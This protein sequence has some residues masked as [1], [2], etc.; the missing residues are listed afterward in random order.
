MK[1]LRLSLTR[2]AVLGG[3][4]TGLLAVTAMFPSGARAMTPGTPGGARAMKAGPHPGSGMNM[5]NMMGY[6]GLI[7]AG[8]E[9]AHS[10]RPAHPAEVARSGYEAERNTIRISHHNNRP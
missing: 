8:S 6:L 10:R 1:S 3:L 2:S 7:R 9:H 5:M 4:V